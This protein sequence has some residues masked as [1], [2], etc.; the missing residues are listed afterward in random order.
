[1]KR[2]DAIVEVAAKAKD[3]DAL[4]IANIGIPCKELYSLCDMP[5]NFYM[6]GSMGLASSIGL[7]VA[8]SRPDRKV[9][10]IEGDGSVL[11]NMGSLATIASQSPDNYLLVIIDNGAYG[12]TG[13]QPTATSKVTD[14]AKVA[15]GAGNEVFEADSS[16]SLRQV[17]KEIDNG[18]V[19]VRAQPGNADVPVIKMCPDEIMGRFMAESSRPSRSV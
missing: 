15:E 18:V 1:M 14:L 10:A 2:I 17:L 12:S 9:I 5:N 7:G 11:M 3:S 8:L 6:L 19:V 16:Q 13:N 4:L